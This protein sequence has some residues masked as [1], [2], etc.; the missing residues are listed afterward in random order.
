MRQERG[1]LRR[2]LDADS[3]GV[4]GKFYVWKLDEV[5]EALG[6]WPTPRSSYFGVTEQGNFE[7]ANIPVRATPDPEQLPRSRRGCWMSDRSAS[8]RG[9][10]TSA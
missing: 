3:E 8:G 10:T 6:R 9:S 1:R 5:R 2:A 4:E 7:G